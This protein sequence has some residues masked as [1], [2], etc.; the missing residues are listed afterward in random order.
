M[1]TS[2]QHATRHCRVALIAGASRGL[3]LELA[4]ELQGRGYHVA[5][6]ARDAAALARAADALGGRVSTHL[7]DVADREQV[8]AA[9]AEVESAVGGVDVALAVAGTIQVGPA[10]DTTLDQFDLALDVMAAGPIN[11]AWAVL[12]GMRRRRHGHI[13]IVS[14]VGG[15]ISPPHLLAYATAK[16]ASLGFADGL[17]AALAGTGVS[18]TAIVPGLM[19]TGSQDRATFTGDAAAEHAWFA[20]AASAP[21]LSADSRRAAHRMVSGLL[22]GRPLVTITPV[23]WAAYRVR[24][25]APA[26]TTRLMGLANR[27]LPGATGNTVPREG[28]EVPSG[29]ALERLTTLGRRAA[30]RNNES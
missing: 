3:G 21:L 8:A 5:L 17:A 26:T 14:S 4:R 16:F 29:P 24:G 10:E 2:H 28:R 6:V 13:G 19:R 1:R 25:L 15:V 9:V 20:V 11:L 23:A 7:A 22:A 12:P 27:L 30:D 18:A